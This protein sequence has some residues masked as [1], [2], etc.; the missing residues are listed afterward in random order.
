[1][2][3][4]PKIVLL[5]MVTKMPVAGVTWLVAHYAVG[6]RRLGFDVYYVEAHARTPS[7]FM[8]HAD[9]DATSKAVEFLASELGRFGFG[10]SWAFHALHDDGRCYGMSRSALEALYK[11]ADLIINMHG[12]TLPLDEHAATG[13]L[14][15][16]GTDPGE[17]EFE[18][19]RGDQRAIDALRL[20][21]WFFT[22]GLNYGNPDCKLPWSSE[23]PMTVTPPPVVLDLWQDAEIGPGTVMTTIGNW[24][25]HWRNVTVDGETY[26]WSKHH[27][28]LK[29][30]ELPER[31]A[32][33]FELALASYEPQDQQLLESHGWAVRPATT[34]S[35]DSESYR[36]YICASRG[37]FS[38]AK[39]QNVRFRSGWFSE[40][41]ACYLA[42]GRPVVLQDTAFGSFLPSGE[43]VLSFS[44]LDGAAAAVELVN[45]D[46]QRHRRA[47]RD[48][49]R[50]YLDSDVVL[51]A[52]LAHCGVSTPV[53]RRS[54]LGPAALPTHLELTPRTRRPLV[55]A[56][57][58]IHEMTRR[59][60]A[61]CRFPGHPLASIVMVTHDNVTVTRMAAESILTSSDDIA[62]ELIIVDN[63]STDGTRA[64]LEVLASRNA[65]VRFV[66]NSTNTGFAKAVNQ[67]L[68]LAVGDVLVVINND[69]IV[70]PSWL[71]RMIA[72]L[73][74]PDIAAVG[75]VTNR[76][77]NHA[78]IPASYRT[79]GEMVA[80]DA[81]RAGG[82]A[83]TSTSLP[84]LT[85]F[86]M[87]MKRGVFETIGPLDERFEIGLF[88]DDDYGRRISA[89]GMRLV[90]A[91]DVFVHHFGEAAFSQLYASGERSK[92][93]EA[94]RQ[95]YQEKWGIEW[96]PHTRRASRSYDIVVDEVR[97]IASELIGAGA[98]VSVI[99]KGDER[100]V[101]V[102]CG[103]ARH[104]P[105]T[106][107]GSFVWFHPANDDDAISALV[108]DENAGLT[109]LV[110]PE[111]AFWW[112]DHYTGF[113]GYLAERYD[114]VPTA[115]ANV[116][117]FQNMQPTATGE[118]APM[119]STGS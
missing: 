45:S 73:D 47:A 83:G 58:T 113:K 14:V 59:P 100:M 10:D 6:F 40:R 89:A 86:C 85:M 66:S 44:D 51:R 111:P 116:L 57:S 101:R 48:V 103:S 107:D 34:V 49:A 13:R 1:M 109:H 16:L 72:H 46:Y 81:E 11:D 62:H 64:Y 90:C 18:L 33:P 78:E 35:S 22:W 69:V 39:D 98:V 61:S 2:N 37:E 60:V 97:D 99:S 26:R 9:D 110:F 15:Y 32:R 104:F 118:R 65:H 19:Q 76:C 3:R 74:Q 102:P 28:F 25:Q 43:G 21:T 96:Q 8:T 67:G 42:A 112:L 36:N 12:G 108:D 114:L 53:A 71:S 93:F 106:P 7:M 17:V 119:N 82:H 20:H 115:S 29:V 38:V 54:R 30:M 92:L 117:V 4:R 88:E 70:T 91:E 94:N 63:A 31:V 77:G 55:L 80:F 87:A 23:F 75:P 52:M 79:Y 95:R 27:E 24:R 56:D 41:S 50:E 68:S 5:G 84:M 105:A